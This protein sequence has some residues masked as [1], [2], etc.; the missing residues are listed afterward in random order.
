MQTIIFNTTEKTLEYYDGTSDGFLTLVKTYYDISTVKILDQGI[1]EVFQKESDG[2]NYPIARFPVGN[3]NM[4]IKKYS[5]YIGDGYK[6]NF[7]K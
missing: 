2:K 5:E 6:E 4:E 7:K 1:Y 3:T